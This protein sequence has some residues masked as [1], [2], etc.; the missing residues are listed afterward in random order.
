MLNQLTICMVL[1]FDIIWLK[2]NMR[3]IH[4][5]F[6]IK[7]ADGCVLQGKYDSDKGANIKLFPKKLKISRLVGI[8][9]RKGTYQIS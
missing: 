4:Q 6:N 3:S 7:K 2:K 8:V 5:N 1:R 9:G